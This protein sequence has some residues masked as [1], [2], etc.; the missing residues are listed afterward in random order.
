[1]E[2]HFKENLTL[3]KVADALYV[4]KYTLSGIFSRILGTSFNDYLNGL[5]IN[6]AVQLLENSD[7]T[8]TDI[9]Y[10]AGFGNVR[11]FNRAFMK[12]IGVTPTEYR[13]M[14]LSTDN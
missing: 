8:V 1:M 4:S 12:L 3:S 13:R 6:L 11:T 10:E 7:S 2:R 9:A 5:R 14:H